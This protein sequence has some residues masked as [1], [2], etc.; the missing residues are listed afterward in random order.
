MPIVGNQSKE[1]SVPLP[2][3]PKRV[4]LNANQDILAYEALSTEVK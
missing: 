3:K 2:T 1:F 4:F